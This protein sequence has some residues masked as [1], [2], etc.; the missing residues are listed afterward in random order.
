MTKGGELFDR[1]VVG[2]SFYAFMFY[3]LY[4]DLDMY[5]VLW[6]YAS[7]VIVFVFGF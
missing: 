5:F 2:V 3:F 6:T 1:V 4:L 7:C